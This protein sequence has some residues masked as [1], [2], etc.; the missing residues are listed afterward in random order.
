MKDK[1]LRSPRLTLLQLHITR[2]VQTPG[3]SDGDGAVTDEVEVVRYLF[4]WIMNRQAIGE[5]VT[6][7][8]K[9]TLWL[10]HDYSIYILP[11]STPTRSKQD[12]GG[13]H[14]LL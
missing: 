12:I 11:L 13:F 8:G 14:S 6:N 10:L 9:I 4:K 2:K 5:N 1:L 3:D 7:A